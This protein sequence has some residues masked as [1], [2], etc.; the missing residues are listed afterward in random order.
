MKRWCF[1]VGI[2]L[3]LTLACTVQAQVYRSGVISANTTWSG[4]NYLSGDVFVQSGAT[5]TLDNTALDCQVQAQGNYRIYLQGGN[6]ATVGATPEHKVLLTAAPGVPVWGGIKVQALAGTGMK[7]IAYL[8]VRYAECG[9][10]ATPN[11][12]TYLA[13]TITHCR[14]EYCGTGIIAQ[15]LSAYPGTIRVTYCTIANSTTDGIFM[16]DLPTRVPPTGGSWIANCDI[17]ASRQCGIHLARVPSTLK[18]YQNYIHDNILDGSVSDNGIT[19]LVS[20]PNIYGN[21]VEEQFGSALGT[22]MSSAPSLLTN[23]NTWSSSAGTGYG[24][25]HAR[26]GFPSMNKANNNIINNHATDRIVIFDESSPPVGRKVLQNYWGSASPLSTWFYPVGYFAFAPYRTTPGTLPPFSYG[27]AGMDTDVY[28]ELEAALAAEAAE[29]FTTAYTLFTSLI[30]AYPNESDAICQA[31]PHVLSCGYEVNVPLT[32]LCAYFDALCLQHGDDM[33]GKTARQVRNDCHVLM[34]DFD[35]PVEDFTA[36]ANQPQTLTDSV[37]A[38]T[39][40]NQ[41]GLIMDYLGVPGPL[42]LD[43]DRPRSLDDYR[44][45]E[46]DL[47]TLLDNPSPAPPATL[48][49]RCQLI[50]AFPNPFNPTTALSYELRASSHITLRVYDTAGREVATLVDGWREAG[51]HEVTFD[52]AGLASGIY[53][54]RLE[55]G[56]QI[57][58]QKLILLK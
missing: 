55:T 51:S 43:P 31:L 33:V 42:A 10:E 41:I 44:S 18:I 39:D 58:V 30:A 7:T 22:Y 47:M 19:C 36:I 45:R 20:S 15:K 4:L 23:V 1:V 6:L 56:G 40:L 54:A 16:F 50:S 46:R 8:H 38:V 14:M 12:G 52:A 35:N 49:D 28:D 24:V 29:N 3:I 27:T 17:Y 53:F 9:M 32:D 11:L 2:A 13:L 5:L 57:S 26:A 48:P 37:F 25:I 21:R 34:Q